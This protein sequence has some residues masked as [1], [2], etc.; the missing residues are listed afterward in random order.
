V[1]SGEPVSQRTHTLDESLLVAPEESDRPVVDFLESTPGRMAL[2]AVVLIAA[3][4]AVGVTASTTVSDRQSRL[5]TLRSHTEPLADAAQ[6]IYGALSFANTTAATA[7]LSGGVEPQ[8]VRDRYDA[9]IGQASAGLVTASNGVSPNDIHSLTLLTDLSNQLAV[10]AGTIATARANNRAGRPIG[11]AYL[12]GSS[13]WMQQS[14]LPSAEQLYRTQADSVMASG[15]SAGPLHAVIAGAV[16]VLGLLVLAQAFLASRSNRRLNP[17]LVLASVLMAVLAVWLTVAGLLSARAATGARTEGGEP[18]DTAVTARIL[19]QQARADEI[20]GLLKRGADTQSDSNFDNRTA[21]LAQ[22]LDGDRMKG[23]ADALGRWVQSHDDIRRRLAG[24]D[25]PG[26][27]AIA[28]DDGPQHSTH[29]FTRLDTALRD[30]ITRLRARQRDG[31]GDAYTALNG[32]PVGAT[33]IGV[34]AALAV[35]AGFGPRLSEYH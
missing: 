35:A 23:A 22:L 30:E 10:Y 33:A 5:E 13:A 4:L 7:F 6:R 31:I 29:E 17:G 34:L 27:V 15:R 3:L 2:V 20:L 1:H 19:A 16:L 12:S 8:D 24:G 28:R 9:A 18:L 32:L 11:V 26:A 21:Q 25:Y 14:I